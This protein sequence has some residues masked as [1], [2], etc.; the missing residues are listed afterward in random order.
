MFA[1]NS[2]YAP[3]PRLDPLPF[4]TS[5]YFQVAV[6]VEWF[7]PYPENSGMIFGGGG[8][9]RRLSLFLNTRIGLRNARR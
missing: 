2:S 1:R 6:F 5:F 4:D 8:R 7:L 9:Q 3:K